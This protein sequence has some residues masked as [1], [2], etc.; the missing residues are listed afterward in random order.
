MIFIAKIDNQYIL[1]Q[2]HTADIVKYYCIPIF[3]KGNS[4][5]NKNL[6][7]SKKRQ[8][9]LINMYF[10]LMKIWKHFS[11]NPVLMKI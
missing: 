5:K 2:N 7:F 9:N 11:F 10:P 3:R 8:D 6:I 1:L 4:K